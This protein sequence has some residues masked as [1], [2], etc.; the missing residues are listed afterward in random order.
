MFAHT[1]IILTVSRLRVGEAIISAPWRK[2]SRLIPQS[3]PGRG[4]ARIRSMEERPLRL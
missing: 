3:G 2:L 1:R 4:R